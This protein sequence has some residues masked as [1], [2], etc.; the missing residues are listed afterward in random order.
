MAGRIVIRKGHGVGHSYRGLSF[1]WK[2]RQEY[3]RQVSVVKDVGLP[4]GQAAA[5]RG[6]SQGV[7]VIYLTPDEE[8]AVVDGPGQRGFGRFDLAGKA[9]LYLVH[10]QLQINPIRPAGGQR[11]NE[12][13][14]ENPSL[15][16]VGSLISAA[17]AFKLNQVFS[18]RVWSFRR[19]SSR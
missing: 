13:R 12:K 9:P 16:H 8:G 5:G 1:R 4:S 11:Q 19:A 10:A 15:A 18:D 3:S 2:I 6:F 7:F 17:A 14:A